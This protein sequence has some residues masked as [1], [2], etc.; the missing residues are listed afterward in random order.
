MSR[1]RRIAV[2]GTVVVAAVVG[3]ACGDDG[4][5]PAP[6]EGSTPA[7]TVY[8][9]A[10][11]K[12]CLEDVGAVADQVRQ[13]DAR[14]QALAD[15]AQRRSFEVTIDG[16]AVAFAFTASAAEAGGLAELLAVPDDPYRI[17]VDRNVVVLYD[18]SA[19]EAFEAA[20][21]CLG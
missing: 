6:A 19:Q 20:A 15:L 21:R 2:F 13:R 4:E 10:P 17:V 5:R 16:T 11:T 12:R 9:L 8:Q 18:P 7:E 3:T 14:F 1:L